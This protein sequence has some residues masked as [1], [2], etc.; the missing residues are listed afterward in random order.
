M[1]VD[2]PISLHG[3]VALITGAGSPNAIG[4]AAAR[5]M[6][7][8][9]ATLA[10][11]STTER[12]NDRVGEL[13]TDGHTAAGFVA[14]LADPAQARSI[15]AAVTERFGRADLLV[16]NAGMVMVGHEEDEEER[17]FAELDDAS[18]HR[19][20]AMN[21]TTCYNVCRSVVPGMIERGYGRIV[22]VSSV[23]GPYASNPASAGYSAAKAGMDGLTRGLA[24]ELAKHG[25]TVNSVAP[26]WIATGSQLPQET[27]AGE[28]TP[29]G[30][31]GTPE[32]VAELIAFLASDAAGYI[33]GRS[34]V[35]DGGNILQ[36][37]KGPA[38]SYY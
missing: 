22:N 18:W 28:N 23:T 6:G 26:G 27:I 3:R 17:P 19:S 24:V 32:E 5:V 25:I 16:N 36:E 4:M 20:I 34:I 33:I 31:S 9:G 35:V 2:D 14:D 37:Y 29:I 1:D 38:E 30:R 10:I 21:L 12:I 11:A 7:R 13:E 15:V 8:R